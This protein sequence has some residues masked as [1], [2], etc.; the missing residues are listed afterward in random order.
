MIQGVT[1]LLDKPTKLIRSISFAMFLYILSY[2]SIYTL[3]YEYIVM[4]Q[5]NEIITWPSQCP[6]SSYNKDCTLLHAP[7]IKTYRHAP[8]KCPSY[9]WSHTKTHTNAPHTKTGTNAPHIKT[10]TM[11]LIQMPLIQRFI[12]M[13][14]IQRFIQR[15]YT[16]NCMNLC[17]NHVNHA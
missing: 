7:H 13:P 15:L 14:L 9:K 12:K 8:Y 11:P 4:K 5:I 1:Y 3:L 6:S 17:C 2:Y 10:H 16:P